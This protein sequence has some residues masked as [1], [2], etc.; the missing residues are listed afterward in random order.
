MLGNLLADDLDWLIA[1]RA[2]LSAGA[3]ITFIT[4]RSICAEIFPAEQLRHAVAQLMMIALVV[5]VLAPMLGSVEAG[6]WR[7]LFVFRPMG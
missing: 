4:S 3:A 2:L 6:G 1:G 5:P 7:S